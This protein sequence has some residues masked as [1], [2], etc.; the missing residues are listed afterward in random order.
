MSAAESAAEMVGMR[1]IAHLVWQRRWLIVSITLSVTLLVAG[2][3]YLLPKQYQA[4]I[5]VMPVADESTS[6]RLS[7][8]NSGDSAIGGLAALAGL[9]GQG[10]S[11]KAEAIATLQSELLTER[12]IQQNN[13]LQVLFNNDWDSQRGQW[14]TSSFSDAPT[15]WQANRYFRNK[16][17]NVN[18]TVRTGL[19]SMTIT[20][21]D[22]KQ[23]AQWANGLVHST[24]EYLRE[25]ALVES[26]RN[27]AYLEG[28]ASR[29]SIVGVQQA[30]YSLAESEIKKSM[31]AKGRDE[32]ALRVI[33]PAVAPERPSYPL[34]ELWIPSAFF[35][36]L[37]LSAFLTV[38][39]A[40]RPA[41]R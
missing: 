17:R 13:L 3:A 10:G 24:N 38:I 26:A 40:Q 11:Q 15:L 33:D 41:G 25:R 36:S 31:L 4:V 30:I 1:E 35:G 7:S 20:W 28:E 14:K 34:P 18:E 2:A 27:I 22:P 19:V 12:Y 39:I 32:Y 9:S 8:L 16:V 23:A 5:L 37:L 6:G 29:T 21:K